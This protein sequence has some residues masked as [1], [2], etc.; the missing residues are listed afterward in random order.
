MSLGTLVIALASAASDCEQQMYTVVE[1][2]L[3]VWWQVL[4][5]CVVRMKMWKTMFRAAVEQAQGGCI[6]SLSKC[7]LF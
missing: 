6:V 1:H 2:R 7:R 4:V 5:K 3:V